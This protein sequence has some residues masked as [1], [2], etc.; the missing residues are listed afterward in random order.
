MKSQINTSNCVLTLVLAL[1]C[2]TTPQ[3]PEPAPGVALAPGM[4][5]GV[6]TTTVGGLVPRM[7]VDPSKPGGGMLVTVQTVEPGESITIG[8]QQASE[9]ELTP[10]GPTPVTGVGTPEPT[11]VTEIVIE[12]G[13]IASSGLDSAHAA[14]LPLYWPLAEENVTDTSLMWLSREAFEELKGTRQTRWDAD[15]LTMFATLPMWAV[16]QIDEATAE[17]ELYLTAESEF[18]DFDTSVDGRRVRFQAIHAFDD[19]GNE[20]IVLDDAENPMIVKFKFNAVSTGAIGI[21]AG[22]WT[23]IKAVFSGYQV[24]EI[25]QQAID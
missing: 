13:T 14:L 15:A 6:V 9:H 16:E 20:Y 17:R 2:A 24:V 25:N 4:Q 19:F 1:G 8:W 11:P 5:I 22:I 23:L 21:D 3:E 18:V 12:E 10:A 7:G